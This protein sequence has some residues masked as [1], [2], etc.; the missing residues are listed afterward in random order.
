MSEIYAIEVKTI[1]G[2]NIAM[3]EYEGQV[4]LIVNTATRCGFAPQFTGLEELYQKY[5]DQGVA[6][7]GFP[8]NQ[9]AGQEPGYDAEIASACSLN[10]GVT[11]PLFAKVDVNGPNQ[12]P[13]FRLL[14]RKKSGFLGSGAIKWNFTKFLVDRKGNVVKRYAPTVKPEK[15]EADIRKLL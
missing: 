14:K 4:L 15:I 2:R 5:K 11:F 1:D 12:H 8:C 3:S 7:L 10:F 9:F 6:V 13:L